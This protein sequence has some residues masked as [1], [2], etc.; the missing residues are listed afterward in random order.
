MYAYTTNIIPTGFTNTWTISIW[1]KYKDNTIAFGYS[2][3]NRLSLYESNGCFYL[4]YNTNFVPFVG[5]TTHGL[6]DESN[7]RLVDESGN[8]L[9]NLDT[10]SGTSYLNAWHNYVV[11]GNGTT[12]VLYI[13]GTRI[14]STGTYVSL[15]GTSLI[16][17]GNDNVNASYRMTNPISD[18]RLYST[19]LTASQI[20]DLYSVAASLASNG[21][22]LSSG[23]N[24]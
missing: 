2:N 17:S 12:N 3:G 20:S 15:T 19:V 4:G 9:T 22:L 6:L 24:E 23:M 5:S 1:A 8:T 21:T 16:I 7:N 11:T 18:F 14:G 10:P 13:D